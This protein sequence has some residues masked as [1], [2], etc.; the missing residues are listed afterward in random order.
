MGCV[1][2]L[3]LVAGPE[4]G[5]HDYTFTTIAGNAGYGSSDGPGSAARFY[6]PSGIAVD[7][8]GNLLVTDAFNAA[9][10]KLTLTGTNW[11][12]STIAGR[13]GITGS[14]DGTNGTA[15]F[16]YPFAVAAAPNGN[17]FVTDVNNSTIRKLTLTGANWMVSTIAGSA[18]NSGSDNGSNS[19]AR[20]NGPLGAAADALGNL[21]VAD[22]YS[23][24][25]RK[26]TP[27]GTNWAV[28]TIAGLA[29]T[30]GSDNGTNDAALFSSPFGMAVDTGGNAYVA[31]NGNHTIRKLSFVGTNCVV[32]TI[33]GKAGFS[34]S[35][36]GANDVARFNGPA[37][38]A[39]DAAGHVY[40]AE[41]GNSV[42]RKLT[43]VGTNWVVS[44]IAGFIGGSA[45]GT[46]NAA[47][48]FQPYG[49]AVDTNG[50][51]YVADSSNNTIRKLT[52]L[53]TDWVVTTIAGLTGGLGNADGTN[54]AARFSN[55]HPGAVDSAGNV[56]VADSESYRIR[57]LMPVGSD[58][59]VTTIAGSGSG[60]NDGTNGAAQ[61]FFPQ[62][63]TADTNGN[64]FV[65]DTFNSTIRKLT[66]AGTNWV[67][68]TIAGQVGSFSSDDGTN[69][70]ARFNGPYALA[71]D[72][73]G[74]VFVADTFNNT[75][76]K[77][78]P[79]GTNWVVTTIAG[80]AGFGNSGSDDGTNSVARFKSPIGIVAGN[81]GAVFVADT[82][83]STI[84][85]LTP[86][87]TNW[88]TTTIT[89]LVTNA[90]SADGTNGVARFNGPAGLATDAS[91]NVFVADQGNS[92][93][94]KLTPSGTNWVVTTI[95]GAAEVYGNADGTGTNAIFS[96][97]SS[98]AVD[99]A[100]RIFVGDNN[101]IRLGQQL[102]PL[103]Q[104]PLLQI[105]LAGNQVILSWPSWAS[106]YSL[107]TT[108]ALPGGLPWAALNGATLSG[109]N[110]VRT[111]P[112]SGS[113]AFFRLH[114]Q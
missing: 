71:A 1:L 109:T 85:K 99:S 14:A 4:A 95:G 47:Q 34:G 12:V 56:Y 60:N 39:V 73:S 20:F 113:A 101:T 50:I 37:G 59:L 69:S 63:L 23:H 15:R 49:I 55:P 114:Q 35:V 104:G 18:G 13:A 62:G 30:P 31:D 10:R 6:Q 111:N 110:Y 91:G 19:V 108:N 61:F 84:R 54:I 40:V 86:V 97:P 17:V 87:G 11:V 81:G 93:I 72:A 16:D 32:T 21:L 3:A 28:T 66:P 100:G 53:G 74:N 75:I 38:V 76:R 78:T 7:A 105:A 41:W 79:T 22:A 102:V 48:F 57:K 51:V 42:I 45:D 67:V 44:T 83:N 33:A 43:P 24:T 27:V 68:T 70:D 88:V 64:L 25:I 5:A 106:N 90:G 58:W 107:E 82:D 2:A 92:T 52:P 36:N 9:I 29:E 94:R 96:G 8:G 112:I 65:A 98:L 26:L 89:G 46:N 80:M 77:I 103:V